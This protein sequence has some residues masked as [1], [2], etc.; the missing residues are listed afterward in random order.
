MFELHRDVS[1]IPT[2]LLCERSA[3]L[4]TDDAD[5]QFTPRDPFENGPQILRAVEQSLAV[6][7]AKLVVLH[8]V[9]RWELVA[10]KKCASAGVCDRV[11]LEPTEKYG[12]RGREMDGGFD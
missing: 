8:E 6:R 3:P 4:E 2:M 9:A 10:G 12:H 5:A 1:Q 11:I 7:L